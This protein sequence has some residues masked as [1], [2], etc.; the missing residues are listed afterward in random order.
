MKKV[1]TSLT[2]VIQAIQDSSRSDAE[3]VAVLTGLLGS[4]RV[5]FRRDVRPLIG[6]RHQL[7][8]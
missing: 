8:H 1:A 3:A 6:S 7:A 2:N 4:G 5:A